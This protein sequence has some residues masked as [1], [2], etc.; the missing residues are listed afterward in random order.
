MYA[1]QIQVLL[2]VNFW[3]FFSNIFVSADAEPTGREKQRYT[4]E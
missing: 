3:D 1:Q 2:F 4:Q